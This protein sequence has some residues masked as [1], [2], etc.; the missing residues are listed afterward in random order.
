VENF[1]MSKL[2]L[3]LLCF[4]W[5]CSSRLTFM[6]RFSLDSECTEQSNEDAF[7]R[8]YDNAI[9]GQSIAL[10]SPAYF[11]TYGQLNRLS[12]KSSSG[13][14]SDIGPATA[15]SL[16]FLSEVIRERNVTSIMDI[17]CG[18]ANWQF[19][20][21]EMDSLDVYAGLDVVRQVIRLNQEKF[22]FH[23][24]KQFAFWDLVTCP[25]PRFRALGS[26]RAQPFDLIHVR[27]V[28]QHL[29]LSKAIN[30]IDNVRRSGAR[31][32]ISTSYPANTQTN[33]AVG[34]IRDGDWQPVNLHAAPFNLTP[35]KCVETHPHIEPDL[36]CLYKIS[37]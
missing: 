24:N 33:G 31:W 19:Q 32:L 8:I 23:S 14:G 22:W 28:I 21:W 29:P 18:D 12:R 30:A 1:K 3:L 11:Y 9:W 25:L 2:L 4:A 13:P 15:K 26:N 10:Q 35:V 5:L 6:K 7:K 37:P 20:S 27:D 36:T 34:E 17:P 16:E